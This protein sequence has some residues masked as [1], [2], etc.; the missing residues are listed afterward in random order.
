MGIGKV[1]GDAMQVFPILV[2]RWGYRKRH[3]IDFPDPYFGM[4]ASQSDSTWIESCTENDHLRC[5]L[6]DFRLK[7]I[8]E[9]SFSKHHVHKLRLQEHSVKQCNDAVKPSLFVKSKSKSGVEIQF[10][11]SSPLRLGHVF[12]KD[13]RPL[14]VG[15]CHQD[16]AREFLRGTTGSV[17]HDSEAGKASDEAAEKRAV[18]LS[19]MNVIC[20]CPESDRVD[21]NFP[22][23]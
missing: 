8:F 21:G 15:V 6:F 10:D 9:E 13:P 23:I 22:T 20:T 16:Q 7:A 14:R 12:G 5:P 19:P 4:I 18:A 3:A 11:E 17:G 1:R 2:T